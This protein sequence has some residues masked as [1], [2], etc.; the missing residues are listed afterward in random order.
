M[1]VRACCAVSVALFRTSESAL[2]AMLRA[3]VSAFEGVGVSMMAETGGWRV[4]RLA[5]GACGD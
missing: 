2:V 4:E 1:V 3:V 5:L